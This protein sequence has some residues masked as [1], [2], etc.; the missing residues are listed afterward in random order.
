[1]RRK[2]REH[3]VAPTTVARPHL[4]DA[5]VPVA[6]V[7]MSPALPQEHRETPWKTSCT[8]QFARADRDTFFSRLH[9][10]HGWRDLADALAGDRR[11]EALRAVLDGSLLTALA[12][13]KRV[14][15]DLVAAA[16]VFGCS[17]SRK[18]VRDLVALKKM[19]IE[20]IGANV[21]ISEA[22]RHPAGLHVCFRADQQLVSLQAPYN[23]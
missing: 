10:H 19:L 23:G 17:G 16:E 1:M 2:Q 22:M 11:A 20:I 14:D 6:P 8:L 4:R 18:V 13:D 12:L 3:I 21:R 5:T 15:L 9:D 7:P